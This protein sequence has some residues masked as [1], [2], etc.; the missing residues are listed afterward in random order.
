[1]VD[2]LFDLERQSGQYSFNELT[3]TTVRIIQKQKDIGTLQ[4]ILRGIEEKT[5]SDDKVD[6]AI[7][8]KLLKAVSKQMN[9]VS[10]DMLP[11]YSYSTRFK[12]PIK[13]ICISTS[14]DMFTPMGLFL[15]KFGVPPSDMFQRNDDRSYTGG[16]LIEITSDY[17][18]LN[19]AN[20]L[21]TYHGFLLG[22][23]VYTPYF[24]DTSVFPSDTSYN[25]LDRPHASFQYLGIGSHG[26]SWNYLYRWDVLVKFGRIGGDRA[27]VLQTTLHQDVSYSPRPSGWGAQIANTGRIGWSLEWTPARM[28]RPL[29]SGKIEST[30]T[31][32]DIFTSIT[33]DLSLGTY[34]THIGAGF[35]ISNKNFLNSNS[36]YAVTRTRVQ[37]ERGSPLQYFLIA[38]KGNVR[39]VIHNTM[40][41]GYGVFET[42]EDYPESKGD[43]YTPRSR[44]KLSKGQVKRV[45]GTFDAI[46][47][48]QF[49]YA[50]LFYRYSI[51]TPE[52]TL[53]TIG[54]YDKDGA[55]LTLKNR[56]HR[57][58]TF[59][60]CFK[61][62]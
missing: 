34:M 57:W 44:Y 26:V 27:Q 54:I 14:N 33:G 30:V 40:L 8:D 37:R 53:G 25:P 50:T 7:E 35:E 10:R 49:R 18:K 42:T 13:S 23:D 28:I 31:S 60:V 47:S 39:Y 36:N 52:T 41:E 46:V 11:W 16:V 32:S 20:A 38:L 48:Y 58:A 51:I 21:K 29:S 19:R 55:E 3:N 15:E 2:I 62:G 17:L 1:M 5:L 9:L 59:G 6:L 24:K 12:K 56:W 22:A 61:I 43:P 45:V 4:L